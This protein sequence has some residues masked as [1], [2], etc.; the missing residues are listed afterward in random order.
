MEKSELKG[1][2]RGGK[3]EI[4]DG[5]VASAGKE[6]NSLNKKKKR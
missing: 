3:G 4:E 1:P 6:K 2:V 5:H